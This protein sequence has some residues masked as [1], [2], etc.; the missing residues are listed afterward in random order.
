MPDRADGVPEWARAAL[1]AHDR[2]VLPRLELFWRYYRNPMGVWQ[3]VGGPLGTGHGSMVGGEVSPALR[4]ALAQERGLPARLRHGGASGRLPQSD[5]RSRTREVVIENDIA[6]RVQSMVDFLLPGAVQVLSTAGTPERRRAIERVLAAV[7]DASGGLGMLQNMA[8]LGH[9][10]GHVDL[11]LR[12]D[13]ERLASL[14]GAGEAEVLGGVGEA[15]WVDVVEPRRGVAVLEA[16]DYRRLAGYVIRYEGGGG[17]GPGTEDV[18]LVG[19]E[20]SS[21][22]GAGLIEVFDAA[23]G[24]VVY[25]GDAVVSRGRVAPGLGPVPVVHM[26]N[27]AEPFVYSGLGEVEP[28]VPLQDELNARL[29]DRAFRV[30]MQAFRMYLAKGLE[31]FDEVPVG[32]GQVWS[33]DNPDAD[34]K[35]IGGDAESPSETAHI[36]EVREAMDKLSSVP[37]LAGGVVRARIGSLSSANALRLT[38]MGLLSKTARKRV[39]YGTGIAEVSRRVLAALDAAGV[40][41]TGPSERGVRL[42]WADAD[43]GEDREAVLTAQNKLAVGVPEERVLSELGYTPAEVDQ[44][45]LGRGP[46]RAVAATRANKEVR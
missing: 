2:A 34:V 19:A 36:G 11:V 28:L 3:D 1:A 23:G 32:P 12:S 27:L 43:L 13:E 31:G 26:Q 17:G 42:E 7:W 37:P 29:S 41:A 8:L 40:F 24:H 5:D 10:Y 18:T 25:T 4:Y 33:T 15:V 45:V 30:S 39:T 38:L 46:R 44:G 14:A 6:W 9:V 35:A 22:A 20:S 16:R 21:A